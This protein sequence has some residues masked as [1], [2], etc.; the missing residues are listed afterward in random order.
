[1]STAADRAVGERVQE[2][3]AQPGDSGDQCAAPVPGHGVGRTHH[4]RPDHRRHRAVRPIGKRMNASGVKA[5]LAGTMPDAGPPH[6]RM[7]P[8]HNRM[9]PAPG[10]RTEVIIDGLGTPATHDRGDIARSPLARFLSPL[11]IPCLLFSAPSG[12]RAIACPA[13]VALPGNLYR[14]H[15]W[16]PGVLFPAREPPHGTPCQLRERLP[17]DPSPTLFDR[18]GGRPPG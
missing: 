3:L 15:E 6:N 7:H 2:P 10:S 18:H 14:P 1:M 12:T 17:Y 13:L 8:A 9:H 11:T 4:N 5:V 16:L